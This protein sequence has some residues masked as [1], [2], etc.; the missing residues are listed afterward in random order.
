LSKTGISEG[1]ASCSRESSAGPNKYVSVDCVRFFEAENSAGTDVACTIFNGSC[2]VGEP[3]A[4]ALRKTFDL[5]QQGFSEKQVRNFQASL[6]REAAHLPGVQ[7]ATLSGYIPLS[8]TDESD[9]Q[10]QT[11][12]H[13]KALVATITPHRA[14]LFPDYGYLPA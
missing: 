6:S 8:N 14:P 3:P 9:T 10:I 1:P 13:P 12:V 7:A 11:A 4:N 2:G 5:G